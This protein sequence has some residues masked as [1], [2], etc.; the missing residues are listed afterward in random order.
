MDK[1]YLDKSKASADETHVV[2]TTKDVSPIAI[3]NR[4]CGRLNIWQI[5]SKLWAVLWV[6]DC[7]KSFLIY[8]R[9]IKWFAMEKILADTLLD[10]AVKA[11]SEKSGANLTGEA[12]EQVV[13][14]LEA[15]L[16]PVVE[17]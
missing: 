16:D 3:N 4:R 17:K 2:Q 5:T 8:S 10:A 14:G 12:Q 11:A 13:G 15:L 6:R 7:M 1:Q 9:W